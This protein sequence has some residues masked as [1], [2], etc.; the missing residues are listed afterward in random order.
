MQLLR[1]PADNPPQSGLKDAAARRANVLGAYEALPGA[2]GKHILLVDDVVTSGATLLECA[3][4]LRDAGAASVRCVA[5]ATV[6][7]DR[8]DGNRKSRAE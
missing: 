1:K 5:L 2:E 3:R 8:R 7:P 4:V 6:R